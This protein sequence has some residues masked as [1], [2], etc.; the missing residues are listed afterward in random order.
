LGCRGGRVPG[1][2][3]A[4]V[5]DDEDDDDDDNDDVDG[6]DDNDNDD[7][8]D[9]DDNGR[10]EAIGDEAR[11]APLLVKSLVARRKVGIGGL[12]VG[13]GGV[14]AR[15]EEGSRSESVVCGIR[16]GCMNER[17]NLLYYIFVQAV[18]MDG[19]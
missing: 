8:D 17:A 7:D 15:L 13:E 1:V 4:F 5:G 6:D 2:D 9:D 12:E 14:G 19:M 16:Y 3:S 11:G 10:A 18:F